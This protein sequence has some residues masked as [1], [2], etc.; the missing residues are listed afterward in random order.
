MGINRPIQKQMDE[1]MERRMFA[2][3]QK[4]PNKEEE[5]LEGEGKKI[6]VNKSHNVDDLR[7][8]AQ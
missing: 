2:C 6:C 5:K 3:E 4:T 8:K 7:M 1:D